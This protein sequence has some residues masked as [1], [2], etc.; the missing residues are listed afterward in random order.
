[1]HCQTQTSNWRRL[2]SGWPPICLSPG[3]MLGLVLPSKSVLHAK[4]KG[5]E[6]FRLALFNNVDVR[7][8]VDLSP[9]RRELFAS[10]IGPTALLIAQKPDGASPD[11]DN[12]RD[13]EIIHVAV[14]LRPFTQAS[15]A[16]VV[17]PE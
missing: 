13:Q 7:S 5:A 6:E 14:H 15:G 12:S 10:A 8:V 11:S 1:M 2:L 3:G 9:I 4:G 16:L 17:A